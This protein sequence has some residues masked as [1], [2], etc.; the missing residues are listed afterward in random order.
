MQIL[1]FGIPELIQGI[2]VT[3]QVGSRGPFLKLVMKRL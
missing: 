3:H 2:G 1:S